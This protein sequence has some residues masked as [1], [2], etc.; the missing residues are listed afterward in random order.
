LAEYLEVLK[1]PKF[2]LNPRRVQTILAFIQSRGINAPAL[3]IKPSSSSWVDSRVLPTTGA[4][5]AHEPDCI[6]GF[7][8]K[9]WGS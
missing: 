2:E 5:S 8:K 7:G 3:P 9:F 4:A 1:R 6:W